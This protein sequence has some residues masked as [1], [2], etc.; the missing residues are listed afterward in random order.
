MWCLSRCHA[1]HHL[2]VTPHLS[3]TRDNN[4]SFSF[5]WVYCDNCDQFALV[6]LVTGENAT[7]D[8]TPDITISQ[9]GDNW[10][11]GHQSRSQSQD[12]VLT[13]RSRNLKTWSQILIR[14]HQHE[15]SHKWRTHHICW[16]L[17]R[18][19]YYL[20]KNHWWSRDWWH[21]APSPP[22]PW[23]PGTAWRGWPGG[24]S[25]PCSPWSRPA[26]WSWSGPCAGHSGRLPSVKC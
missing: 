9:M 13:A 16:S 19:T 11:C 8:P 14:R 20:S 25:S 24:S 15:S 1:T 23:E 3:S 6:R 26:S 12:S 17:R 21:Q 10:Q 2:R 7:D 5:C 4:G 22:S 18:A